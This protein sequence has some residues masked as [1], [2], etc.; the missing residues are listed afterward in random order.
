MGL[1]ILLAVAWVCAAT[2]VALLPM[3][4]QYPLGGALMLAAPALI[5]LIGYQHG[6]LLALLALAA[7]VSMFRNPLRLVWRK[8]RGLETGGVAE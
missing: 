6:V 4:W 5:V 8:L 3:R 7:F 2:F 1:S